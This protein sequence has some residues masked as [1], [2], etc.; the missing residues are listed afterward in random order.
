MRDIKG[1]SINIY[2]RSSGLFTIRILIYN[3]QLREMT[4][5]THRDY[6]VLLTNSVTIAAR[7]VR[8]DKDKYRFE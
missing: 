1:H 7:V 6:L 3:I 5:I 2:V 4:T 8:I